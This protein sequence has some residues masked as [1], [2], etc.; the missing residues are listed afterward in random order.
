MSDAGLRRVVT[1]GKVTAARTRAGR[2]L[3]DM[4]LFDGERRR[5]VELLLPTGVSALPAVGAD[6]VVLEV[7][8]NRQHLVAMVADDPG[9]RV[10]DLAPGEFGFRD[11]KGQQVIFRG[12]R[13]DIS[14]A[15]R[16]DI[17]ASGPVNVTAAET[18]TV[19][20]PRINLGAGATQKVKLAND[21][22]ASKV[23]AE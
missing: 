14:G 7:G 22:A 5:N 1:R 4:T 12:D 13:L 16:I 6:L 23:Y 11:A 20:A 10:S 19:E 15:L 18:V 2:V 17:T 9:L 3:V 8:G 21:A